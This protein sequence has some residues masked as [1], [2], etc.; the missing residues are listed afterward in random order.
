M[1]Q[2]MLI[3]NLGQDPDLKRTQAGMAILNLSVATSKKVKEEW[4]STWHRVVVFGK[5]AEILAI[6]ARKGSKLFIQGEI[7]T[8]EWT[9]KEGAKKVTT[10][11]LAN[12]AYVIEKP[13]AQPDTQGSANY[14]GGN[15]GDDDAIP[16]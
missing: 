16:F 1:N 9:D 7:Q 14:P 6:Q 8:R 5:K 12:L 15:F 2:A 10:E 11:I 3:G 13:P 4:K